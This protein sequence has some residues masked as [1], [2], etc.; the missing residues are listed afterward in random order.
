MVE[1][2]VDEYKSWQNSRSVRLINEWHE[3]GMS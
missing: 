3:L 2:L 1:C